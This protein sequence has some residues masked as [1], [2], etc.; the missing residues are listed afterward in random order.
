ARYITNKIAIMYLGKIVE[1]G[2]TLKVIDNPMHPY[3]KAL[4]EAIPDPDPEN[5]KKIREVPIKGEVPS[6]I[7]VPPGCR[8]HP[9]C[10]SFDEHPEIRQYCRTQEP[11]LIEVEKNHYVACWLYTRPGEVSKLMRT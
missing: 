3:T 1:M 9:R 11:P 4:I 5:R 2:E 7:Y 6:A 8:F 10:L